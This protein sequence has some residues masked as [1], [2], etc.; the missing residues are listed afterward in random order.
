MKFKHNRRKSVIVTKIDIN[1]VSDYIYVNFLS[2]S[3]FYFI[4][5]VILSNFKLCL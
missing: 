1:S 3:F 4:L 5:H 2:F